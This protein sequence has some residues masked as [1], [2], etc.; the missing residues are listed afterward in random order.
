MYGGAWPGTVGTAFHLVGTTIQPAAITANLTVDGDFILGGAA[1][2]SNVQLGFVYLDGNLTLSGRALF[3]TGAAGGHVI[4]GTAGK[5]MALR[6]A[7]HGLLTG[8]FTN[9]WT[10]PT[11]V[12]G[13]TIDGATTASSIAYAANVGTI[14]NGITTSVANLDAAA[15]AAG[16]GGSAFNLGGS[17][18]SSL[19]A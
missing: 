13:V 4:Y 7:G 12:T 6:D 2:W 10:A 19:T 3:D 1:F 11:L 14:H 15:G 16:F 18:V 9:G 5:V 17:S 8:T